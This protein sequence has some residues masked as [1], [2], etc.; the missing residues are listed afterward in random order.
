MNRQLAFF[1]PP[2]KGPTMPTA[3]FT[4][5]AATALIDVTPFADDEPASFVEQAQRPPI[6]LYVQVEGLGGLTDYS[7]RIEVPAYDDYAAGIGLV[8][9]KINELVFAM[10]W[11][12]GV[13]GHP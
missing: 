7:L 5:G 9:A 13:E 2:T 4:G 11:W 1:D 12:G 8:L 10:D 6:S 3:D